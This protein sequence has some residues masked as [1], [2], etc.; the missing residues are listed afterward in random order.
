MA[1][2]GAA[3]REVALAKAL[4]FGPAV[5]GA[6]LSV[7]GCAGQEVTPGCDVWQLA[8]VAAAAQGAAALLRSAVTSPQASAADC[9][10]N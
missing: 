6:G 3:A 4:D 10:R 8:D 2:G 7:C 9:R 1:K 5:P